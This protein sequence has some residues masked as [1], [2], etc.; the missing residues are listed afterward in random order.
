MTCENCIDGD[1]DSVFPYYGLAPHSHKRTEDVIL[2]TNI[3]PKENWP[4]NFTEDY[5]CNGLGV[6]T[7]CLHCETKPDYL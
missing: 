3:Q 1:G 4:S 2:T 5:D 7:H 6:Y